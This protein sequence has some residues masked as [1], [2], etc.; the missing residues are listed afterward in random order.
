MTLASSNYDQGEMMTSDTAPSMISTQSHRQ[1]V[2]YLLQNSS[3]K[4]GT[5]VYPTETAVTYHE[6]LLIWLT[7]SS[8][9]QLACP[10]VTEQH[11]GQLQS[12]M[13]ETYPGGAQ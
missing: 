3:T 2:I 13:F 8:Y 9:V 10:L 1:Y 4:A 7:F 11:F 5:L 12:L 6:S